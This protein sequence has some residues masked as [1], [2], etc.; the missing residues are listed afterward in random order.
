MHPTGTALAIYDRDAASKTTRG[1]D[2]LVNLATHMP[3]SAMH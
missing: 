2:V 1:Y 3:S